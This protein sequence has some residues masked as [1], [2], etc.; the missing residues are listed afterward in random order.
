MQKSNRETKYQTR[1][2]QSYK[3]KKEENINRKLKE[4]KTIIIFYR[5]RK[6]G[7]DIKHHILGINKKISYK[8][9]NKY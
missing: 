1:G 6:K 4:L 9:K 7:K 8:T 5:E 3:E 2:K